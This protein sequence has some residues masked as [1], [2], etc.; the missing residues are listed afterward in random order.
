[1]PGGF[2]ATA[3]GG[4]WARTGL[5][6]EADAAFLQGADGVGSDKSNDQVPGFCYLDVSPQYDGP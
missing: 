1:M 2:A 6:G 5:A 4:R 3:A